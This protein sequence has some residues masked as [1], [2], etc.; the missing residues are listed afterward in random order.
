MRKHQ[1]P[2]PIMQL[3]IRKLYFCL[4][5]TLLALTAPLKA[6]ESQAKLLSPGALQALEAKDWMRAAE[7]LQREVL[8]FD[9]ATPAEKKATTYFALASCLVELD[10]GDKA[11]ANFQQALKHTNNGSL[12]L[13][14]QFQLAKNLLEQKQAEQALSTFQQYFREHNPLLSSRPLRES[15]FLAASAAI[16]AKQTSLALEYLGKLL[17]TP[18]LISASPP[19]AKQFA[20]LARQL[21]ADAQSELLETALLKSK[22]VPSALGFTFELLSHYLKDPARNMSDALAELLNAAQQSQNLASYQSL[23][24]DYYISKQELPKAELLAES[25]LATP[26]PSPAQQQAAWKAQTTLQFLNENYRQAVTIAERYLQQWPDA[27][28]ADQLRYLAARSQVALLETSEA[29]TLLQAISTPELLE[30]TEYQMAY[31]YYLTDRYDEALDTLL[32][33]SSN[34]ACKALKIKCLILLGQTYSVLEQNDK[35]QAKLQKAI[36]LA[37]EA[38]KS[39]L[40]QEAYFELLLHFS[41]AIE[42]QELDNPASYH[43]KITENYQAFRE[44]FPKSEYGCQIIS[45]AYD[46]LVISD[47]QA[48][49][50]KDLQARIDYAIEQQFEAGLDLAFRHRTWEHLSEA[51]PNALLTE[52]SKN[53]STTAASC[54]L[55]ALLEYYTINLEKQKTSWGAKLA[56]LASIRQIHATLQ[57]QLSSEWLPSYLLNDLAGELNRSTR[58]ATQSLPVLAKVKSNGTLEQRALTQMLTIQSKRLQD[59]PLKPGNLK[60]LGQ[61]SQAYFHNPRFTEALELEFI[62]A[63]RHL[64]QHQPLTQAAASFLETFPQSKHKGR[65]RLLMGQ[66]YQ[67][68]QLV[69]GAIEQYTHIFTNHT[70]QL[71]V[72]APA[73]VELCKI[74]WERNLPATE[75]S[76]SDRQIAYQLGHRYLNLILDT[77]RWKKELPAVK[78]SLTALQDQVKT[79][80][81]SGE[82]T[83]VEQLLKE[84]YESRF[85]R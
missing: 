7:T 35:A 70:T 83:P 51:S 68:N 25:I 43:Q 5:A 61:N 11:T 19:T 56:Y 27:S 54:T 75:N 82:V 17:S 81:Q 84:L 18:V 6:Q 30:S 37:K 72:S 47:K 53:L 28:D 45:I 55:H 4:G 36:F 33:L 48:E 41:H 10:L 26:Q 58:G 42:T 73:M 71:E 8:A 12:R 29:L 9:D 85:E 39:T 32:E 59:M 46:S 50:S 60:Q 13:R 3:P 69:D 63:Q 67:Q 23:A 78:H 80:E 79:W 16:E 57:H 65:V 1:P 62:E 49:A 15:F 20:A 76:P 52:L 24:L 77:P 21:P 40:H 22:E 74:T 2:H 34:P 66:S 38:G 14:A 44:A 64:K 31:I